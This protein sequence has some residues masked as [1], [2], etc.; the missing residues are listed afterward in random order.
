MGEKLSVPG[1]IFHCAQPIEKFLIALVLIPSLRRGVLLFAVGI[2]FHPLMISSVQAL[3]CKAE[4]LV[5]ALDIGHSKADPGARSARG[6]TEY[7]FNRR[8]VEELLAV[9]GSHPHLQF[10]KINPS[11]N[12]ISLKARTDAAAGIGADLF[13]SIHHDSVNEKYLKQ[14]QDGDTVRDHADAFRGFSLFVS[15]KNPAFKNS[16]KVARRIAAAFKDAGLGQTLHHA[17]PIKGEDRELIDWD[18]GVYNVPFSVLRRASMP[19]VL[20]ELGVIINRREE[21]WLNQTSTRKQMADLII[22]AL[23]ESCR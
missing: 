2:L 1:R 15:R 6:I 11:G 8:F 10:R 16:L 17:E 18:L 21:A 3:D 12:K 22:R 14:W 23:T 5:V 9:H 19:S 7:G 20:V 13:L 4:K